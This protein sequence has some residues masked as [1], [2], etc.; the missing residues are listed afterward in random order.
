MLSLAVISYGAA[1]V[2]FLL[3]SLFAVV[4]WRACIED[5]LLLLAL[6][7]TFVWALLVS[8]GHF[9][10]YLSPSWFSIIELFRNITWF[11]LLIRLVFIAGNHR[12]L[13]FVKKTLF[14]TLAGVLGSFILFMYPVFHAGNG[15][16]S[17]PVPDVNLRLVAH[18]VL[19]LTGLFLLEQWY[20]NIGA[21]LRWSS[22]FLCLGI[23]SIFTFDF[24]LY[25]DALLF[26]GVDLDFWSVRGIIYVMAVPLVG[27]SISR[28]RQWLLGDYVSHRMAF[29]SA[30]LVVGGL[31]LFAVALGGYYIRLYGGGWGKILQV[32]FFFASLLLLLSLV[33]SG[34]LRAQL[35]V[36]VG[37]HFFSYK[38]DY[39]EQWASFIRAL[40]MG[41]T[42]EQLRG[43]AIQA[44]ANIV[45]SPG[46]GLWLRN[47]T[48]RG[49]LPVTGSKMTIGSHCREPDHSSLVA[50]LEKWQWVVNLGEYE[51]DPSL[52]RDLVLPRWLL[53][54]PDAW[55]VVPLMKQT[56][57]LGF[58][59][60]THSRA[61]DHFNW[62]D[63]DL[64]RI[65]GRELASYLALLEAN[66]ELVE[67]RQFET[68]NR[69]SAYVVHDLKNV[70]GQ[71][72]LVVE[73]SRKHKDNPEFISDAFA[74]VDNATNKMQRMLSQLRI[75]KHVETRGTLVRIGEVIDEVVA[76]RQ[77][78][79]P[80]PV[81]T[82]CEELEVVIDRDRLS[83]V[84]E[85]VI[86][87]AQE[88]T[89]D[90]GVI[91][92][93]L[94]VSGDY[95]VIKVDDNGCGMSEQ[96][97]RE[98]LFRP[99]DTTKGNAGMGIGVY[100]CQEFICSLGGEVE[101]NSQTG[102]GTQFCL[103]IPLTKIL[104]E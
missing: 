65:A 20:R 54:L 23:A 61:G 10:A 73:N 31:Y 18:I 11:A 85:H 82:A 9:Y 21:E 40:S 48:T 12:W 56:Q 91:T 79:F 63:I 74:T 97:V 1:A 71:L 68:F 94:M 88:A 101:V 66:R 51:R 14:F 59:V 95:A 7:T 49:F 47:D 25:S 43:R 75:D 83:S 70:V 102:E 5:A 98:R 64:L 27:I 29:H 78:A 3:L 76:R 67:A 52:Y 89:P 16:V 8:A 34:Q 24:F 42:D 58:I 87:N 46:G 81:F 60:L 45:E 19:S 44:I 72:S 39:R 26:G 100:E 86:D 15:A 37:K 53:E 30:V 22:K 4:K 80:K 33:F 2:A 69:L 57:L 93:K 104:V 38:Y 96:F 62:E 84:I 103:S 17:F 50:F 77:V 92:V 6:V 13:R 32:L 28:S 55:L 35:K 41:G 99:F 36:F 90:D